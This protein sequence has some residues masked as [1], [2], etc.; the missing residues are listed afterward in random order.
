MEENESELSS[1]YCINLL[2]NR[3]VETYNFLSIESGARLYHES[4]NDIKKNVYN[5]CTYN[6]VV[7]NSISYKRAKKPI[8][9]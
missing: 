5:G 6:K 7:L 4:G 1:D 2:Y 3:N 8:L 9:R